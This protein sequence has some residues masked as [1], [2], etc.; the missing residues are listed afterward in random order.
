MLHAPE[1]HSNSGRNNACSCFEANN[2]ALLGYEIF[3]QPRE[4]GEE[5]DAKKTKAMQ[6]GVAGN[7]SRD[8]GRK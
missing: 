6:R 8:S 7:A 5:I 2:F 1:N 3:D 4:E